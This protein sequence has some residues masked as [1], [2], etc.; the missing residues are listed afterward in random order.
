MGL[1]FILNTFFLLILRT[2]HCNDYFLS[3]VPRKTAEEKDFGDFLIFEDPE[4][5]YST[6]NFHYPVK[7]F[8]RLA[9]LNEFNTLLGEQTIRDVIAECVR[10]R[11]KGKATNGVNGN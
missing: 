8:D 1:I 4:S 3:G 6:F 10:K 7:Q 9:D 5:W 2:E 11:Q